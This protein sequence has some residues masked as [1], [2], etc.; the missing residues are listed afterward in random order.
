MLLRP[1][2]GPNFENEIVINMLD[3]NLLILNTPQW[4]RQLLS[5][6]LL[7]KE[8][9]IIIT[10]NV[11]KTYTNNVKKQ[12]YWLDSSFI[13]H[14]DQIIQNQMFS[15]GGR[16]LFKSLITVFNVFCCTF[17]NDLV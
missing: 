15:I 9:C 8:K 2:K 5:N 6:S 17:Y 3:Q 14:S 4:W 7:F 13:L 12:I 10:Q 1:L 16:D 11:T